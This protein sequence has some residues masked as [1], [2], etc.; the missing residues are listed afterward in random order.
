MFGFFGSKRIKGDI[1][2]RKQEY[3]NEWREENEKN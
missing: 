2:R 3:S 1:E